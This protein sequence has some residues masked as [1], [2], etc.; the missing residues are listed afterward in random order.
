MEKACAIALDKAVRVAPMPSPAWSGRRRPNWRIVIWD[1]VVMSAMVPS[2][3]EAS[4]TLA[5]REFATTDLKNPE[6][7]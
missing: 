7:R 3:E 6:E 4:M 1:V 5:A 2:L